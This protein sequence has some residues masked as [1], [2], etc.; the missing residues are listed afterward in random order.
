[1]DLIL[2]TVKRFVD[3]EVRPAA[4]ELERERP[5]DP[6]TGSRDHHDLARELLHRP[7]APLVLLP[8]Y[9]Y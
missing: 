8:S 1:L 5:P 4:R 2:S 3:R 6:R 7:S 9:G